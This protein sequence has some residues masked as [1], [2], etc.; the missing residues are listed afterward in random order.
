MEIGYSTETLWWNICK[1]MAE[2]VDEA[3]WL[4]HYTAKREIECIEDC[5]RN[6][7]DSCKAILENTENLKGEEI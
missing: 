7:M 4:R 2:I 1:K 3:E 5:A 6:I